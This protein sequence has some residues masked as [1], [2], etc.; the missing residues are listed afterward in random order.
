MRGSGGCPPTANLAD[1]SPRK[2][3]DLA[4]Q[5]TAIKAEYWLLQDDLHALAFIGVR[6]SN[7]LSVG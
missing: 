4:D 3:Q 5:A 2:D 7:I 6:T 1:R